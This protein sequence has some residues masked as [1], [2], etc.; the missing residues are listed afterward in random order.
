MEEYAASPASAPTPPPAGAAPL[1]PRRPIPRRAPTPPTRP[2][3]QLQVPG[4]S[5]APSY[6]PSATR[7][8]GLPFP[9]G[10]YELPVTVGGRRAAMNLR[11]YEA[12][13]EGAGYSY[14]GGDQ[15]RC[16]ILRARSLV[17]SVEVSWTSKWPKGCSRTQGRIRVAGGT[18]ATQRRRPSVSSQETTQDISWA[19][20]RGESEGPMILVINAAI[21]R[22]HRLTGMPRRPARLHS[23]RDTDLRFRGIGTSW[24]CGADAA[25]GRQ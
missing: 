7:K 3:S 18:I 10:G 9:A 14:L 22:T 25:R 24:P 19:G 1:R 5:G 13:R 4:T 15:P 2:S 8:K 11:D 6:T 21:E 20:F 23:S 17:T 16:T 12:M